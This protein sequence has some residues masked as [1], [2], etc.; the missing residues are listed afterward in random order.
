MKLVSP[1]K[2][3]SKKVHEIDL[4]DGK[5]LSVL[6][7]PKDAEMFILMKQEM[8]PEDATRITEVLKNI[9]QRANEDLDDDDLEAVVANYYG[10][11]IKELGV[12]FGFTTREQMDKIVEQAKKKVTEA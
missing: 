3:L 11:L 9:I 12:L 10:L 1:F 8:T 2:G 5:K 6:P 4:G 7:K